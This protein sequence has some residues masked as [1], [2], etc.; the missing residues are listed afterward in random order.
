M[1]IGRRSPNNKFWIVTSDDAGQRKAIHS[2][3]V[4]VGNDHIRL[5]YGQQRER[6]LTVRRP[7]RL[8]TQIV[9]LLDQHMAAGAVIVH[10]QNASRGGGRR[11]RRKRHGRHR[12]RRHARQTQANRHLG[13]HAR[14]AVQ[15]Q[16]ASHH[17]DQRATD[18]KTKAAALLDGRMLSLL[19]G[20]KQ[21]R[22]R[23]GINARSAVLNNQQEI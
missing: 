21:P 2:R 7:D 12:L 20:L 10:H 15:R 5:L 18:I 23:L 22:L 1:L 9:Q 11:L 19:E 13:A 17:G 16:L 4:A 6:L 8:M 14:L 3:H